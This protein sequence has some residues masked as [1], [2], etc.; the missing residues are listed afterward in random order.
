M[1][2]DTLWNWLENKYIYYKKTYPHYD[3]QDE[4]FLLEIF[5]DFYEY[6]ISV[7]KKDL[8]E[9]LK[10]NLSMVENF[11]IKRSINI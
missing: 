10:N 1:I 3:I 11:S 9:N 5:Y 8:I 4:E 7:K 2:D 6:L